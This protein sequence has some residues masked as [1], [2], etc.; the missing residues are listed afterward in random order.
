MAPLS[1]RAWAQTA[2][3]RAVG[4]ARQGVRKSDDH[5]DALTLHCNPKRAG[6][7]GRK[8]GERSERCGLRRT[9]N[10]SARRAA[11]QRRQSAPLE[12]DASA[13]V[14][15]ALAAL[16]HDH[17]TFGGSSS[18][19]RSSSR[20]RSL[21]VRARDSNLRHHHLFSCAAPVPPVVSSASS[22]R[23]CSVESSKSKSRPFSA[24]RSLRTDFGMTGTSRCTH[25]R[26]SI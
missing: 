4:A 5:L 13:R 17:S 22:T 7:W 12:H 2:S 24:M 19:I 9:R 23:I 15:G 25:H 6:E 26:K 11:S 10:W 14:T 16:A 8:S 20:F 1:C 18:E 21:A 3:A